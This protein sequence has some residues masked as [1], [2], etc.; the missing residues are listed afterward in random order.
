M[1]PNLDHYRNRAEV[2]FERLTKGCALIIILLMIGFFVQLFWHSLPSLKTFGIKFL[3]STA[4]DPV[5]NLYGAAG[6]VYGTL[7][8]TLIALVIAVPLSFIIALFLVELAP[9]WLSTVMSHALD[10][11]AAIPSIIYGMWDC[12]S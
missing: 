11:L 5:R 3:F 1:K 6:A 4:W 9:P 8:T 7:I 2:A 10:L 12:S